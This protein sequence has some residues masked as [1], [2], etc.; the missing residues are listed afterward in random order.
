MEWIKGSKYSN[1]YQNKYG[2]TM[3]VCK[4][5]KISRHCTQ[6]A[7]VKVSKLNG[8]CDYYCAKCALDKQKNK[9]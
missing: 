8:K 7:T 2:F 9:L 3:P 4:C 5:Y 1:Y 6:Y